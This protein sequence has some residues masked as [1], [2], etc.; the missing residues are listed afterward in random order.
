MAASS[1]HNRMLVLRLLDGDSFVGS[2]PLLPVTLPGL[3]W[4]LA[5]ASHHTFSSAGEC[6]SLGSGSGRGR[7]RSLM[8]LVSPLR[9]LQT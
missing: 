8:A 9:D 1:V 4:I 7:L 5:A 3:A 6:V 2:W